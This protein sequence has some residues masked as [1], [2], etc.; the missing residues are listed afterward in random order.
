MFYFCST[1]TRHLVPLLNALD[2]QPYNIQEVDGGDA[3]RHRAMLCKGAYNLLLP[4]LLACAQ[5]MHA[6]VQYIPR[7][8][9][10]LILVVEFFVS[11]TRA[12]RSSASSEMP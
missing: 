9:S 1:Q 8:K 12:V 10:H 3:C 6:C 4:R 5:P 7:W 2:F 11:I